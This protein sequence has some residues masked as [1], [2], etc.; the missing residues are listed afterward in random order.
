MIYKIAQTVGKNNAVQRRKPNTKHCMK[1]CTRPTA[2]FSIFQHLIISLISVSNQSSNDN[3][4]T[5]Y[6]NSCEACDQL[7]DGKVGDFE[8]EFRCTPCGVQA[9]SAVYVV[10]LRTNPRWRRP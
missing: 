4:K 9:A 7:P 10:G 1:A 8:C 5:L 6:R 3:V 2:I